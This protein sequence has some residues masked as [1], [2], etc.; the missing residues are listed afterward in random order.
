MLPPFLAI[1]SAPYWHIPTPWPQPRPDKNAHV[2][3]QLI[4]LQIELFN[5]LPVEST[6]SRKSS[7]RSESLLPFEPMIFILVNRENSS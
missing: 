1:P 2:L 6:V 4:I 7:A 3:S 5:L